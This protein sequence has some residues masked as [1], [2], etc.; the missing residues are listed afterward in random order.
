MEAWHCP[1]DKGDPLYGCKNCFVEYGNSYLPQFAGESFRT[2][3]VVGDSRQPGTD[4]GLPIKVSE[5]NQSPANKIVQGDWDWHGNRD[6]LN[7]GYVWHTYR[8]Q[9]RENMLFGDG[10]V[11]F[12]HFPDQMADWIGDPPWDRGFLWW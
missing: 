8:G 10:H 12:F 6:D 7:A 3:H 1:S 9:R 11:V 4:A 5:V 2:K